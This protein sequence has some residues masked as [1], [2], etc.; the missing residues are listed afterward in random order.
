[1]GIARTETDCE[2]HRLQRRLLKETLLAIP[3]LQDMSG[4]SNATFLVNIP[5]FCG[6][7]LFRA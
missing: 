7:G 3:S 2:S 1:M 4:R 5:E 6:G